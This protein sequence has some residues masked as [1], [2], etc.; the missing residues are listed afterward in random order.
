MMLAA[1]N[2]RTLFVHPN[3][4]LRLTNVNL[5]QWFQEMLSAYQVIGRFTPNQ[6]RHIFVDERCSQDAVGGPKNEGAAR[7][8]GNSVER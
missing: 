2:E 8:M 4:G 3:S 6:L 7:I 5:S 1:Q